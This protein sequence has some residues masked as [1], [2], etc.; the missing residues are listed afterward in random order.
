MRNCQTQARRC[1]HGGRSRGPLGSALTDTANRA[2]LRSETGGVT[3]AVV[4]TEHKVA[5][6]PRNKQLSTSHHFLTIISPCHPAHPTTLIF[7]LLRVHF[8]E[9]R[10]ARFFRS[11][12]C[13]LGH[14]TRTFGCTQLTERG[15]GQGSVPE[16]RGKTTSTGNG[17]APAPS[18][19]PQPTHAAVKEYRSRAVLRT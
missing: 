4:S 1:S 5:S 8:L 17:S 16:F 13:R 12:S 10:V 2:A 15:Q 11:A 19:K 3:A 7:D 6:V 9:T 18:Q 14:C